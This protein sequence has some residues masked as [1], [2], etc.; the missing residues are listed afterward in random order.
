QR[1][2]QHHQQQQSTGPT[3]RTSTS[4]TITFTTNRTASSRPPK[5]NNPDMFLITLFSSDLLLLQALSLES[6]EPQPLVVVSSGHRHS[7]VTNPIWENIF[8]FG[9]SANSVQFVSSIPNFFSECKG[10]HN[11]FKNMQLAFLLS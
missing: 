11:S 10:L 1:H 4:L 2:Q 5:P 3:T 9:I 6:H 8:Y 7:H